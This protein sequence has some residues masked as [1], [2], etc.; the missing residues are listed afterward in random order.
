MKPEWIP[1]HCL[2]CMTY[3]GHGE[4]DFADCPNRSCGHDEDHATHS[5]TYVCPTCGHSW[6]AIPPEDWDGSLLVRPEKPIPTPPPEYRDTN[7]VSA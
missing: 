7:E 4:E 1:K 2:H 5:G 6:M 3:T